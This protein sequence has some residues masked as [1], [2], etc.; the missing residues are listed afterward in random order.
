MQLFST[1]LDEMNS[2]TQHVTAVQSV[3]FCVN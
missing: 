2:T 1:A 3:P